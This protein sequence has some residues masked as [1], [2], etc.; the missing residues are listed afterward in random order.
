M[1][2]EL[3]KAYVQIVP[4]ASGIKGSI[5]KELGGEADAAGKSAGQSFGGKMVGALKGII[6][7]AGIGKIISSAISEGA[8]LEQSLGGIETLFKDNADKVKKMANEAYRTA[9]LSANAYMETVTS[10]SAS[11]LQGL[12]GD[13]AK[14][15]DVSDMAI[16]DMADNANKMGTSMDLIQNAYQGFAKQNYT[17]LDNLKLG[18]GGTKT[19]MER[20]LKDAQKVSGVKYDISNLSDVY[21]AIHVIQGE[22]DITGTTAKEAASTISGSL[23]AMKSSFSNVLAKMT[24]GEDIGPALKALAETTTTF[25][26]KNLLPAVWNVLK[27]LPSS[28]ITILKTGFP[29]LITGLKSFVPQIVTGIK[30]GLPQLLQTAL[31]LIS[32]FANG[33]LSS[34]PLILQKGE[35][36]L[37]SLVDGIAVALPQLLQTAFTTIS[38]FANGLIENLPQILQTGKNILLNVVS[39]IQQSFPQIILSAGQAVASLIGGLIQHLPEILSAGFDLIISLIS[40]I[41]NAYPDIITAIGQVA[42]TIWTAITEVD[43]L[44]LGKDIILGMIK[45][46]GAM[47]G[48]LWDAAVNIAK[49]AL[50]AIKD[51]FGIHSPS[52]VMR[53]QVGKFIPAGIAVG[54]ENNTKPISN[55]MRN[56]ADLTTGTLQSDLVVDLASGNNF[57]NMEPAYAGSYGNAGMTIEK[58][59]INSHDRLSEAEITREIENLLERM[60]WKNH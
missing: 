53:D 10:F 23:A 18:Y 14:A 22:L 32:Q 42:Q 1:A 19:E 49:S 8:A 28:I 31:D 48:A 36:L 56:L 2:T 51:F 50:D 4:S 29:Q 38:S 40:G 60:R 7:A 39:G 54:I 43:W 12:G 27:A 15:A 16:T 46:I 52:T 21:S 24:L 55:A 6:I 26:V 35:E 58:L 41:G 37:S 59:E 47:A 30:T 13:T 5:T 45:G 33:L 57:N 20:L 9:G 11:L 3:A 44:Q 17:M 34:M 25:L